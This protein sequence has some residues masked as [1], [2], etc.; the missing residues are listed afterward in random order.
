MYALESAMDELAWAL[1]MDPVALRLANYAEIDLHKKLPFSS[2]NLREC[3]T[4]GA[5]KFGWSARN[6]EI[7]AARDGDWF[8]G[9]G[10]ASAYYPGYRFPSTARVRVL[11]DGSAVVSS[12][13]HDLGTG[14]YTIM[15]QMAAE[16]L[17]LPV[18]LVRSELGDSSLPP[19]AIAGGSMSTAS[20]MPAVK[21]AAES[22]RKKI[23]ALALKDPKSPLKDFAP[24]DVTIENGRLLA[25]DKGE[26]LSGVIQRSGMAAIE[27]TESSAPGPD[28]AKFSFYSYGAQFAE[29]RV[30]ALT[31]EVRVSRFLSAIDC[32]RVMNARTTRSQVIGG[33]VWGIGMALME[34]SI[35]DPRTARFTTADLGA[36]H[37]PV[38][39]DIP[40]IEVYL[41]DKPDLNFNSV[42]ARGV[43]EIGITG[44]AAA[45]ANA[46]YHA[47]GQR[48]RELPITP[49]KILVAP[50]VRE[51]LA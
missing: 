31:G 5:E 29:V 4:V 17:G 33:V 48:V 51:P 20:V 21:A 19:A 1:K 30:H 46:V 3:Y 25:G 12:A 13:T 16:T 7:R 11:A 41:T 15:C 18:N 9:V 40:K 44:V 23:I 32:G 27:A 49:D 14:M 26:L 8:V 10:M 39:A 50:K 22:A 24:G 37:V 42:G 43:G 38:N 36:Y 35:L 34:E 6:P 28:A 45:I 2:K 47:T